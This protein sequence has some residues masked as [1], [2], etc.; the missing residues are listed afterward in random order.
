MDDSFM[1]HLSLSSV[2]ILEYGFNPLV[3]KQEVTCHLCAF[4]PQLFQMWLMYLH[5]L[6]QSMVLWA[7]RMC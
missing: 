4:G 2:Q 6:S 1:L 3:F 7:Q 5:P